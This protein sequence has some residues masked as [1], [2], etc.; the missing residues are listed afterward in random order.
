MNHNL[1]NKEL[2]LCNYLILK[3]R[4]RFYFY[5]PVGNLPAVINEPEKL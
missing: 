3:L 2:D 5:Y 1:Y 4:Q